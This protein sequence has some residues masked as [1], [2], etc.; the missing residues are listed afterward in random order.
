L[1][2]TESSKLIDTSYVVDIYDQV[3]FLGDMRRQ[4]SFLPDGAKVR[5]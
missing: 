5:L 2:I 1:F 3:G 4:I